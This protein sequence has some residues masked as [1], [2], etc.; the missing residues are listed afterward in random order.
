MMLITGVI[1]GI[2]LATMITLFSIDKYWKDRLVLLGYAK[3]YLENGKKKWDFT[4][5][6]EG[7]TY[8]WYE[9]YLE[10]IK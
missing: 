9:E 7:K 8:Q 1:G 2:Y 10:R 3:Y 4:V 5:D 6:P